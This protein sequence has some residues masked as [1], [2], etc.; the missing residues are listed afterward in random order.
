MNKVVE[1]LLV[2]LKG[3]VAAVI[4]G[5]ANGVLLVVV[6]PNEFNLNEGLPRLQTVII[7]SGI[8]SAAAYLKQS[9]V[10]QVSQT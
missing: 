7:V 3:L 4:G 5:V 6:N 2:W 10:P 9:P 1:A 8:V